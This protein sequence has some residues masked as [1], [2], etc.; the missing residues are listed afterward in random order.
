MAKTRGGNHFKPRVCPSSLSPAIG[1]SSTPTSANA[2]SPAPVP[3]ASVPRRYSMRVGPTLPSP[4][5]PPS[6]ERDQASDLGKSSSSRSQEPHSPHVQG[7]VDDLPP[8]LSPVSMTPRR[9]FYPRVVIEFYHTMTSRRVPHPTVIHF[10][11]LQPHSISLLPQ[12]T[13][14]VTGCGLT[15]YP[16]RWFALYRET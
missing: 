9:F 13:R 6:S 7:P 5:H 10:S 11:I 4:A 12:L 14:L 2:A 1:Q 8:D 15:P 3:T 16:E